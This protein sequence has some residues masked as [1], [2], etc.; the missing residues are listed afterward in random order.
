MWNLSWH[1]VHYGAMC[2]FQKPI[3]STLCIVMR[4][5]RF[6]TQL[7]CRQADAKPLHIW[8]AF[9]PMAGGSNCRATGY[10]GWLTDLKWQM[11]IN[12]SRVKWAHT[13]TNIR[14][15]TSW[16]AWANGRVTRVIDDLW[17]KFLVLSYCTKHSWTIKWLHEILVKMP[18]PLSNLQHANFSA[19]H[20]HSFR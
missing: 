11:L 13:G 15:E 7:Q 18:N 5:S 12:Y 17:Q 16:H 19:G 14:E 10:M 3:W 6:V 1:C 2:S 8:F 9:L 4:Q 20:H